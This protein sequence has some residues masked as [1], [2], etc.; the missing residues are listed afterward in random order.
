MEI[1]EKRI[2]RFIHKQIIFLRVSDAKFAVKGEYKIQ[3]SAANLYRRPDGHKLKPA[4][5][6]SDGQKNYLESAVFWTEPYKF[7]EVGTKVIICLNTFEAPHAI[8]G[9]HILR[10]LV[11]VI[12]NKAEQRWA[13]MFRFRD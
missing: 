2:G 12:E 5:P 8:C 9:A 3:K 7:I 11:G 6:R 1:V 4:S 13:K 10:E